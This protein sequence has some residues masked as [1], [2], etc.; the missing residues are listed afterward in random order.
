MAQARVKPFVQPCRYTLPELVSRLLAQYEN[1][2]DAVCRVCCDIGSKKE[3][4]KKEKLTFNPSLNIRLCLP[5]R[6]CIMV[7]SNRQLE[8]PPFLLYLYFIIIKFILYIICYNLSIF[9]SYI[10]Y[11]NLLYRMML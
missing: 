5:E 8:L 4:K 11:Y 7:E 9:L 6:H 1:I 3:T 2:C 10:F